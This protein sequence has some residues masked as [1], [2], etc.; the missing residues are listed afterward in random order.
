MQEG[1]L[2]GHA[3]RSFSSSGLQAPLRKTTYTVMHFQSPIFPLLI[4]DPAAGPALQDVQDTRSPC[5]SMNSLSGLDT[6][7]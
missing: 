7:L 4:V 5:C 2:S 6:N 1:Y 3:A